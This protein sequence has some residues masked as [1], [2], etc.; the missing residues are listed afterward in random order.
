MG[1]AELQRDADA[2]LAG[3]RGR[4]DDVRRGPGADVDRA[5]AAAREAFDNGPW[6]R[7]STA[8]RAAALRKVAAELTARRP[9]LS[10]A[11]DGAGRCADL[12]H[13]L[14]LGPVRGALRVLRRPGRGLSAR[15][16]AHARQ[17]RA[18]ARREG[19]GRRR[20]G[21]HPVERPAGAALLQGRGRA[22]RRLHGRREARAR[23]AGRRLH[24]RR[25]HRGRGPAARRV[26]R[27][28]RGPRGRRPPRPPSRHRQDRL[29][30]QHDRRPQDRRGGGRAARAREPGARRQVRRGR[31]STTPRSATCS[32]ASCRSR[33]RS[34]ARC[35]SR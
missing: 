35:A 12:L 30:G 20:R 17:R 8:E 28:A 31:S 33:C 9:A 13:E 27:R 18:R 19:A 21:H 6:P 25:V 1:G 32:R 4:A 5:V 2:H 3:D 10:E 11:V 26:Q 34:P 14:R 24:P 15:R 16:R 7:M 23:D 29:H 22:G